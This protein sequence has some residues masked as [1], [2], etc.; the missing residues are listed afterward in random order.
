MYSSDTVN[1]STLATE[2][3][4]N[5]C[6]AEEPNL[7]ALKFNDITQAVDASLHLWVP[8]YI[9]EGRVVD[10]APGIKIGV[11]SREQLGDNGSSLNSFRVVGLR[12]N[13]NDFF[14]DDKSIHKYATM[15]V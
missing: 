10:I 7:G 13:Y 15:I 12:F 14:V 6:N 9:I 5:N 8:V 1:C 11:Q 2:E 3:E 4:Q